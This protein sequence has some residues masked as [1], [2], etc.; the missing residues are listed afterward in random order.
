MPFILNRENGGTLVQY[1]N[2]KAATDANAKGETHCVDFIL[3]A[4]PGASRTSTHAWVEG[5]RVTKGNSAIAQDTAIAT[6]VNGSYSTLIA[7]PA[8]EFWSSCSYS[9]TKAVMSRPRPEGVT[10][11]TVTYNP[12]QGV[13]GYSDVE[14]IAWKQAA[15]PETGVP[16]VAP[17]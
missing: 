12:R 10:E 1:Y 6:L 9:G 13:Q 11:C 5:K 17:R 4:V 8:T 3:Q 16:K 14:R 2:D 7:G 15:L